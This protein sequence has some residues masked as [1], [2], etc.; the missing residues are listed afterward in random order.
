MN[1]FDHQPTLG[2]KL[3]GK[4]TTD[5][6][7]DVKDIYLK[8]VGD[9]HIRAGELSRSISLVD[10][11]VSLFDAD[12]MHNPTP[13][14]ERVNK[15]DYSFSLSD[16]L[17]PSF[18][19]RS[20][21]DSVDVEYA[22]VL[23]VNYRKLFKKTKKNKF[24]FDLIKS[25]SNSIAFDNFR[26]ISNG[27]QYKRSNIGLDLHVPDLRIIP[28]NKPLPIK[29]AITLTGKQLFEEFDLKIHF[30]RLV[31]LR[32][33]RWH[34]LKSLDSLLFTLQKSDMIYQHTDFKSNQV[35]HH[36]SVDVRLNDVSDFEYKD[37]LSI[38]HFISVDYNNNTIITFDAPLIQLSMAASNAPPPYSDHPDQYH[39]Q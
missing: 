28:I 3:Q 5:E 39:L 30:H 20:G 15:F 26:V 18:R 24:R 14:D 25:S 2:T 10:D 11:S 13:L 17:P 27:I 19:H 38:S 29:L 4:I 22:L 37:I 6:F 9:A 36:F 8:L 33:R 12:M 35:T 1:T 32:T 31:K 21:E 7:K 16:N 23:C 34:D